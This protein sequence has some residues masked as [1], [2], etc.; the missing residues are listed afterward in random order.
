MT[1]PTP[2]PVR[3]RFPL[4]FALPILL[5]SAAFAAGCSST[6]CQA[7]SDCARGEVC[8]AAGQCVTG[9]STSTGCGT[10]SGTTPICDTAQNKCVVCTASQGCPSGK[11]CDTSTAGGRCVSCTKDANCSGLT[12]TCD[13]T[14]GVCIACDATHACSGNKICDTTVSGGRCVGCRNSLDCVGLATVCDPATEICVRCTEDLGCES[15]VCDTSIPGGECVECVGNTDCVDTQKPVCDLGTHTCVTDG[16]TGDDGI[17]AA[18]AAADGT[19][20]SLAVEDVLVTYLKPLM[21]TGTSAEP[22]GFFIQAKQD[23]P[24][25]FVAVDPATLTPA[26][27]VGDKVSFTIT[28]LATAKSGTSATSP[29]S[30]R[31]VMGLTSYSRTSAGN[32]VASLAKDVTTAG[33]VVT[34]VVAYE[35]RIVRLTGTI[36]STFSNSGAGHVKAQITTTGIPTASANFVLRVPGNNSSGSYAPTL[37]TNPPLAQGCTF[38]LVGGP[39]WRYTTY[40]AGTPPTPTEYAQAH[41]YTAESIANV[42][43]SPLAPKVVSAAATS[44]TAVR[45]V[46]DG[47]LDTTSVANSGAQFTIAPTL[48]VTAASAAGSEVTLTTAAQASG[49]SYTVTVAATVKNAAGTGVD[50]AHNSATFTGYTSG[51][52]SCTTPSQIVISQVYGGGGNTGA[53]FK[54]DFVELHNRGS[55]SVD[56]SAWSIQYAGSGATSAWQK[57]ALTGSIGA[58]KFMLVS[59]GGGS[60]GADLPTPD[61]V[62]SIA[63]SGSAGKVALVKN[64]TALASGTCPSG[65]DLVD[66]VGYGGTTTACAEGAAA[67]A[68]TNTTAAIRQGNGCSDTTRND[69][70]F[71]TGAPAPHNGA[72]AASSC[73][74]N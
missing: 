35:S 17:A 50:G 28:E 10:C 33:D 56:V 63:M 72:T 64:Q 43:C 61:V 1:P 70:D 38:T 69:A 14:K 49:T 29:T 22:A 2:S 41:A 58:G 68:L 45:V 48:A 13:T 26:A 27:A 31:Q 16:G 36:A 57:T 15:G 47:A 65:A 24:A 25:L 51:G 30:V 54:K 74:C 66:L 7:N 71:A 42:S 5:V 37:V 23:G 34:N 73:T 9:G 40:Q 67:P 19:G 18:R 3:A 12:P 8:N 6:Q 60:N 39:I 52:G 62:G 11:F 32:G 20:L 44:A 21:G 53:P 4:R 55:T 59:E 46:F